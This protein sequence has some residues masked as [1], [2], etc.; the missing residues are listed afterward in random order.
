MVCVFL[1]D[2]Y[3]CAISCGAR[4]GQTFVQ[5]R[6]SMHISL[7]TTTTSSITFMAATGQ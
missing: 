6:H 7:S 2:V 3:A 4:K 1:F 5:I